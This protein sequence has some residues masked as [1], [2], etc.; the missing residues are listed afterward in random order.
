MKT[1]G[2]KTSEQV[3][4]Y[5]IKIG[6]DPL[7]VQGAGGNASW[8]DGEV[9]WVKASGTWLAHAVNEEIFIPVDLTHL[10]S[11]IADKNFSAMPKVLITT[12]LRPSIETMLHALMPH[13]I[14]VHLHAVEILAHL[15]RKNPL[16]DLRRLIG[17]AVDWVFIDYCKPGAYLA[18]AVR[19][20]LQ[21]KP[22]ANV[23]FLK[24]HGLVIGGDSI[25]EINGALNHILKSLHTPVGEVKA[26]VRTIH[27][28]LDASLAYNGYRPC[29]DIELHFLANR[30]EFS[31]RLKNEWALYPDHVVFLGSEPTIIEDFNVDGY[32]KNSLGCPPLFIFILN[33][34]VYESASVRHTHRL[35][36]RCYF[37]VLARQPE[38]I[39]LASMSKSQI[40]ELL[41]WEA[42]KY[43]QVL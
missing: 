40:S 14:V 22:D 17:N 43:R 35:Q 39:E 21:E 27:V 9:L 25:H 41:D 18:S 13:K 10:R 23:V 26:E 20:S 3:K 38:F 32:F 4:A 5:C 31:S 28:D 7:L 12:S 11:E 1:I 30:Y 34:G 24:S 37:D 16:E 6:A 8:K 15:V 2:Q 36:L 19:E 33:V 42:E 29:G